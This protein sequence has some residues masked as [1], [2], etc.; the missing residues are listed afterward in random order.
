MYS[1]PQNESVAKAIVVSK[2]GKLGASPSTPA[3]KYMEQYDLLL[4]MIFI[5]I[6][7]SI[8]VIFCI[9]FCKKYH[10]DRSYE[11]ARTIILGGTIG[12]SI[13]HSQ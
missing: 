12:V 1:R 8:I 3:N 6:M 5:G 2:T 13:F 9:Y 11:K 7:C 10:N 4:E